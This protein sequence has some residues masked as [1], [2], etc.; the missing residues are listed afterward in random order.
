MF[1]KKRELG[2]LRGKLNRY[3]KKRIL[4]TLIMEHG[5]VWSR[6][7]DTSHEKNR[8]KKNGDLTTKADDERW[9][10]KAEREGQ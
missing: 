8:H 10:W 7:R 6:S 3:V 1:S 4:K 2:L 5:A 9:I